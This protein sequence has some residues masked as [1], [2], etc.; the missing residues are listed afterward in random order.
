M[1]YLRVSLLFSKFNRFLTQAIARLRSDFQLSVMTLLCASGVFGITPFAIYRFLIG[2]TV[3][4]IL[5]L[6]VLSGILVAVT[7]SWRTGDMLNGGRALGVIICVGGVAVGTKLGIN[8]AFWLFPAFLT[9]Y[10]LTPYRFALCINALALLFLCVHGGAFDS[11]EQMWSFTTTSTVVNA[12]AYIFAVR[13]HEQ[14]QK[15]ERLASHD[16]LTGVKNRRAMTSDLE[17]AVA[18]AKQAGIHYALV[19]LDLDHFKRIND[20][21]G[22]HIGDQVL[23][24]CAQ[25]LQAHIRES[26]KLFRFGGEEFTL[27]MAG[28][29]DKG[30]YPV[31]DKLRLALEEKLSSPGGK[32]TASFGVALLRPGENWETW[33]ARADNALYLAKEGGRNKVVVAPEKVL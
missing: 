8:G 9:T 25:I 20:E 19:M 10:F 32:V 31:V 30:L 18:N 29:S 11:T 6:M 23:M 22:H 3:A 2:D 33:L 28:V 27:L 16:P 7:Y 14:H 1:V 15:L 5:D 12:C 13:H 21:Y 26:D 24:N 4:G 17:L